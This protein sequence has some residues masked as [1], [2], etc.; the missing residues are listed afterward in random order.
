MIMSRM[1]INVRLLHLLFLFTGVLACGAAAAAP[2]EKPRQN[3]GIVAERTSHDFGE[4]PQGEVRTAEFPL[5]ASD[6]IVVLLSASTN[7]EC[8]TA[9]YPRK[10]LRRGE[11]G[12]VT[13]RYEARDKGYFRKVATLR[14]TAGGKTRTLML[15]VSGSV[16]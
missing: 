2:Q 12:V 15:S 8:T 13:V 4:I 16:I 9:S 14:Y 7:C 3:E 11:K 6:D 10:P 1:G 5:T